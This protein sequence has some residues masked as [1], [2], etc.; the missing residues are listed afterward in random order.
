[1]YICMYGRALY[2]PC[3]CLMKEIGLVDDFPILLSM[4]CLRV[5]FALISKDI[6]FLGFHFWV[7]FDCRI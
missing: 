7:G 3:V 4:S 5:S 2:I 1:M 6:H